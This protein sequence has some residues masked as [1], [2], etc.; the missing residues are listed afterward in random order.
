MWLLRALF[1]W[2]FVFLYWVFVGWLKILEFLESAFDIFAGT[3]K[4]TYNG[5]RDYLINVFLGNSVISVVFWGI[6]LISV[7]LCFVFTI[8]A[9]ARK[10]LDIGGKV[11][12]SI[13]Q[14]IT[15]SG[16]AALSFLLVGAISMAAI[17]LGTI[18][19]VQTN[20]L[21]KNA[22]STTFNSKLDKKVFSDIELG[23]MARILN[24]VGN[25][26]LNTT[27][28][29]RYNIN[30][31]FNSIRHDL[32]LLY[33]N[34]FFDY[35]YDERINGVSWQSLIYNIGISQDFKEKMPEDSYNQGLINAITRTMNLLKNNKQ[36]HPLESMSI[37]PLG[38]LG[39]DD[40]IFLTST[41]NASY[42]QFFRENG[43][44]TD[45]LRRS[46]YDGTKTYDNLEAVREDFDIW[47]IDYLVGFFSC[48]FIVVVM[49]ICS[50]SFIIRLV[51]I[52]LL[53][54][55]APFFV[56]MMPLDD[57]AKFA[58]WRQAFL[59]KIIS[60]FGSVMAMRLYLI[61][62]PIIMD[63]KLIFFENNAFF[64]YMMRILFIMGGS[65]AIFKSTSLITNIFA[66]NASAAAQG[67]MLAAGVGLAAVAGAGKGALALGKGVGKAGVGAVKG[68]VS[69]GKALD[70]KIS[71]VKDAKNSQIY[72]ENKRKQSA[73]WTGQSM[74]EHMNKD[75]QE[76][77]QTPP[78][79]PANPAPPPANPA[80]QV[81]T[82]PN[83]PPAAPAPPPIKKGIEMK[84]IHPTAQEPKKDEW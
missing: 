54:I 63:P 8:I 60:G 41:M 11:K 18:V 52:M 65:W 6:T 12:N 36:L 16:M 69:A 71:G 9:V 20:Y 33:D 3:V 80:P 31:C 13:G 46:Y 61:M 78:P 10:T 56:S 74:A 81:N 40:I 48:L 23:A 53:Y 25:F 58:T 49:T 59:I 44:F 14:I 24:T 32:Q 55:S 68:G 73:E 1:D 21:M 29:N 7:V 4:V 22:F 84:P 35:G 64:N 27:P 51:E 26:S 72:D 28:E 47:K 57:G 67:D 43:S 77:T 19:L 17:N 75:K 70:K 37:K 15:N 39:V 82:Q 5:Q 66:G 45:S 38:D 34:G 30:A 2:F 42:S 50:I 62:V 79:P 76:S 83:P